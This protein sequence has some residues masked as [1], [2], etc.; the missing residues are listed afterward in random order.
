MNGGIEKKRAVIIFALV[1]AFAFGTRLCL[2]VRNRTCPNG[3]EAIVGVM[4]F[5]IQDRGVHPVFL[6]TSDHGGGHTVDAHVA[7]LLN[8]VF[9]RRV[10]H[11]LVSPVAA[12]AVF[13]GVCAL[14]AIRA[15]GFP[16]GILVGLYLIFAPFLFRPSLRAAGYMETLAMMSV[17]CYIALG[18]MMG[19]PNKDS[20]GQKPPGAAWGLLTGFLCGLA[21]WWLEFSAV[22]SAALFAAYALR[23]RRR[24]LPVLA[25]WA[26]A[27][28]VGAAALVYENIRN[29]FMNLQHLAQGHALG[30][31]AARPPFLHFFTRELPAFFQNDNVDFFPAHIPSAA[32]LLFGATMLGCAAAL[33]FALKGRRQGVRAPVVLVFGFFYCIFYSAVYLV[34]PFR[35][36]T[37]RYLLPLEP[38]MSVGLAAGVAALIGTRRAAGYILAGLLVICVIIA[39]VNGTRFAWSDGRINDSYDADVACGEIDGLVSLLD[40][41]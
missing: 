4:A 35:G 21:Y 13:A 16:L 40:S 14:L 34:S 23:W 19:D 10:P 5:D 12:F 8:S 30:A 15:A 37:A 24:A 29:G 11:V 32:W 18:R 31:K 7:A 25:A 28:P 6:Y 33:F 22:M 3:D 27:F 38:F 1:V 41:R 26:A 36:E 9:G 39:D 2:A 20:A 17:C